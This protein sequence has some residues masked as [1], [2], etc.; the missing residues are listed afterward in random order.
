MNV[1]LK[2][3]TIYDNRKTYSLNCNILTYMFGKRNIIS[4]PTNN[5]PSF[6]GLVCQVSYNTLFH[7]LLLVLI[8]FH[9]KVLVGV[10]ID[11]EF[12]QGRRD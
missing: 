10:D 1:L 3:E 9:N 11:N 6:S 8:I 7:I 12:Y 4:L 2:Y 5:V